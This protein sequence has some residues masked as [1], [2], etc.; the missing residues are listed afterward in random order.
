MSDKNLAVVTPVILAGGSGTRL[1]PL[2]RKSYPKQFVPLL[3]E[4]TLFRSVV[5]RLSG[6]GKGFAFARPVVLTNATFRFIVA[7]QLA[8]EDTDPRAIIIEP[9]VRNT[10]P[11]ILAAALHLAAGD[12]EAVMLVAPSDHVVPDAEAFRAAVSQGLAAARSGDL[13]TFGIQPTRPETGY[14][15]LQVVARPD[16]SGQP[17]KLARFV[18][19]PNAARAQEMLASGDHLWN[20]GI[21]L[22]AA[23][24]LIAAFEALAPDVLAAV[25]PAVDAAEGDLGFLR[26]SAEAWDAA[27]DISIDYA[28]MERAGNLSVVPYDSGWSDLGGWDAVWSHAGPDAAGVT[29]GGGATAIDC[30]DTLL[31]SDSDGMELVGIG[32]SNIIAVAMNDAVLIA[33]KSRA[34]DVKLAVEALK[35]KGAVQ[36]ESFP[37]DHRPWGWVEGLL[38]GE[39][40]Q[41][42]RIV[43]QPGQSLSLQSHFHR[44]EHWIVVEGTA[45]VTVGDEVTLL[46]EN[47]SLYVP[48]G[49]KHRVENPGKIPVVFIEVQTGT[50]LGEDDIVRYEDRYARG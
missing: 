37:K 16:G 17:I 25:R 10:A 33:D 24:D 35:K 40:F 27:P 12:P 49:A 32:L 21:F 28:I 36:A 3:G 4:Q 23:K 18:E 1:W 47:Q 41:V 31:R 44:S 39:R 13:V 26:L 9:S 8:Q 14:G 20:A 2:S 7:E 5:A 29:V 19:K 45:K 46:T 50:Y 30:S 6:E 11:A 15:Y 48:A 42:K 43:V 38:A 22:F 34:Q